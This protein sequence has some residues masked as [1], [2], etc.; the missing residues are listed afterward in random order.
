MPCL[1]ALLITFLLKKWF[2]ISLLYNKQQALFY[3]SYFLNT[4]VVFYVQENI[5][6]KF[7]RDFVVGIR[8]PT[9]EC[10]QLNLEINGR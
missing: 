8:N 6:Q 1:F 9:N 10:K 7:R 5:Y 2:S 4:T 3:F